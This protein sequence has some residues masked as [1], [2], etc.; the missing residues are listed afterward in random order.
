M[1]SL[2]FVGRLYY[3]KLK[4]SV[5]LCNKTSVCYPGLHS[6]N[7][8]LYTCSEIKEEGLVSCR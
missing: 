3:A 6:T 2:E 1:V 5:R 4:T 8:L 7:R